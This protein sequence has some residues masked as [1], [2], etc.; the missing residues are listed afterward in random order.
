VLPVL[1]D[2]EARSQVVTIHPPLPPLIANPV[3]DLDSCRRLLAGLLGD[4]VRRFP[5]QCFSLAFPPQPVSQ[6]GA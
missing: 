1:S 5:E 6:R 2:M 3:R 4:Y